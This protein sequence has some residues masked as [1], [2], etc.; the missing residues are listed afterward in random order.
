MD[1]SSV[2]PV[3][4]HFSA[5][6]NLSLLCFTERR[7]PHLYSILHQLPTV[8]RQPECVCVCVYVW[9]CAYSAYCTKPV[10][11]LSLLSYLDLTSTYRL[12]SVS[13]GSIVC[14]DQCV[15]FFFSPLSPWRTDTLHRRSH[16]SRSQSVCRQLRL[17]VSLPPSLPPS[18]SISL[19]SILLFAAYWQS[20]S[21][22]TDRWGITVATVSY[23][24]LLMFY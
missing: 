8:R 2:S 10:F 7:I 16:L 14:A 13:H 11:L 9:D 22:H 1:I 18:C 17:G 24:K 12:P 3:S 21:S 6:T 5:P 20:Y 4:H 15:T 23:P 19:S